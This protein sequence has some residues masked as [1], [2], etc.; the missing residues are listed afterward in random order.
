MYLTSSLLGVNKQLIDYCH[1]SNN[2]KLLIILFYLI[3][4]DLKNAF[5]KCYTAINHATKSLLIEL[6]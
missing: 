5:E 3:E 1:H 2:V 4:E 6:P